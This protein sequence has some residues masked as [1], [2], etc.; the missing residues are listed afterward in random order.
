MRDDANTIAAP[1]AI[2]ENRD[3]TRSKPPSGRNS[4]ASS[5]HRTRPHTWD[6]G[7]TAYSVGGED[8][9]MSQA[10]GF[11]GSS[12]GRK[13]VMAVTGVILVGFILVHMVGNMLVY[14]QRPRGHQRLRRLTA[15]APPRLGDLDRA[16]GAARRVVLH[17]WSATSLTLEEPAARP[18][19]VPGAE[20]AGVDLCLAHDALERRDHPALRHLPPDA[21]H[22]RQRPPELRRGRR[23]PQLRRGLPQ[24]SGSRSSTS[25][26]WSLSG[27]TCATAS[28]ACSRRSA[29]RTRATS[30]GARRGLVFAAIVVL[31]NI[32]FPWPSWSGW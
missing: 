5:H 19:G 26:R 22:D 25:S 30:A 8:S 24:T 23:L 17:I 10:R 13:V 11:L 15:R 2:R 21:L 16:R 29:S 1:A 28:G 18:R 7:R 4:R 9:R 32:S 12:I 31:G 6:G 27:S 14:L 20:V 3:I